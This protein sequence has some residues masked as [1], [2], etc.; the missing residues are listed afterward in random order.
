MRSGPGGVVAINVVQKPISVFASQVFRKDAK[1]AK[2]YFQV[3]TG[4]VARDSFAAAA[5]A[6]RLTGS[7]MRIS[8]QL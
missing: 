5:V 1:S 8:A 7:P 4:T 3:S 6:R 2:S